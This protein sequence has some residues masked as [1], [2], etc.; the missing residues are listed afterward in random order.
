MASVR[1]VR[2]AAQV[3]VRSKEIKR[4][5]TVSEV[6]IGKYIRFPD[7]PEATASELDRLWAETAAIRN[8]LAEIVSEIEKLKGE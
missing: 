7:T 2:S 8:K 3:S 4:S 6:V 5:D 1:E